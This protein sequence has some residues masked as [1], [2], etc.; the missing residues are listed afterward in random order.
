[1]FFFSPPYLRVILFKT[2]HRRIC[3][4]INYLRSGSVPERYHTLRIM[5]CTS[6]FLYLY[7]VLFYTYINKT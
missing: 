5:I 4:Q 7:R 1:M 3:M 2:T 6:W